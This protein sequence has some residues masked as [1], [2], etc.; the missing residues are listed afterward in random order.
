MQAIDHQSILYCIKKCKFVWT[1]ILLFYLRDLE[2]KENFEEK[3]YKSNT[4][5]LKNFNE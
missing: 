2:H 5:I 1:L 3:I 4:Q